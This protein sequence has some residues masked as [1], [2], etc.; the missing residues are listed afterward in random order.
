MSKIK[1]KCWW[2]NSE[3]N[4]GEHK[5]KKSDLVAEFGNTFNDKSNRPILIGGGKETELQGPNS[6]Y[7]K[8]EK[9]LCAKCNS[10]KSQNSDIAYSEIIEY[11][12]DNHKNLENVDSLDLRLIYPNNWK[13][14]KLDFYS[15]FVKHFCCRLARN[16]VEIPISI[17]KFLNNEIDYLENINLCFQHKLDLKKVL[18]IMEKEGYE[19]GF[20]QF[21]KLHFVNDDSDNIDLAHTYLT[22]K[23]MR[24]EMYFSSQITKEIFP[25]LIDFYKSP[26]IPYLRCSLFNLEDKYDDIVK[27]MS[28]S[29]EKNE[30]IDLI[31]TTNDYFTNNPYNNI[32]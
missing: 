25:D 15:Y 13:T 24:C 23:W 18:E 27:E 17:I 10:N 30:N 5:F 11:L 26:I 32:M 8:F 7:V 16:N 6:K 1:Y 2:C 19:N 31:R 28:A 22:R 21:G 9:V 20:L 4:S 12:L 29:K 3:G 14:K